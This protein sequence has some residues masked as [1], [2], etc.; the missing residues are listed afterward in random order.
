MGRLISIAIVEDD[1]D[2]SD[3][4]AEWLREL[5]TDEISIKIQ[6]FFTV[7]AAQGAFQKQRFDIISLDLTFNHDE[8][9]GV[10]LWLEAWKRQQ[11]LI[12]VVSG[13]SA[14]FDGAMRALEVFDYIPKLL[15]GRILERNRYL[16]PF[17]RALK[18]LQD[19]RPARLF[20]DPN[21][22]DVLYDGAK[23]R[24]TPTESKI[25]SLLYEN[26]GSIVSL[27]D[28]CQRVTSGT[29]RDNVKK[30]ISNVNQKFRDEKEQT[31]DWRQ[32]MPAGKGYCW[33]DPL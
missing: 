19:A 5:A 17:A 13:N 15:G 29:N 23:V 32:I 8:N 14:E 4:F 22:L 12:I 25:A 9:A 16:K 10:S 28:I 1:R 30:H 7:E 3:V 20:V 31:E 26:K 24:L 18:T 11:G 6:Q 27:D 21:T 33:V 2:L